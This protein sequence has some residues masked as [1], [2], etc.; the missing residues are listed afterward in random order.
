MRVKTLRAVVAIAAAVMA[1]G[2]HGADLALKAP[3]AP[4]AAYS[5]TGCYAG[6]QVGGAFLDQIASGAVAGGQVGCDYQFAPAWVVGAEGAGAWTGLTGSRANRVENLVTGATAPARLTVGNDY[7]ASVT[8]RI[9]HTFNDRWLF[10]VKGGAAWTNERVDDAYNKPVGGEPVDPSASENRT[11][12]TAGTG[13]EWALAR[14]WSTTLE[15]NYYGFGSG[16]TATSPNAELYLT[17]L[18]DAVQTVTVGLNYRF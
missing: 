3:P 7:L 1:T 11:G 17:N 10:Y 4:V 8:A 16:I 2:V 13:V 15:Y 12:W 6:G 9:G 5:W 18:K 14:N